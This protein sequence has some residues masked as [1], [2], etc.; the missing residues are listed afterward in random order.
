MRA[1]AAVVGAPTSSA[2]AEGTRKKSRRWGARRGH[3]SFRVGDALHCS[4]ERLGRPRVEVLV[5]SVLC[6]RRA[7]LGILLSSTATSLVGRVGTASAEDLA[8]EEP[9][10]VTSSQ[11]P[12]VVATSDERAYEI[13]SAPDEVVVEEIIDEPPPPPPGS[14]PQKSDDEDSTIL[15]STSDVDNLNEVDAKALKQN[16]QIQAQNRAPKGFPEFVR[17]GFDMFIF[18]DGYTQ[19]ENGLIYKELEAGE[20]GG[21][22]GQDGDEVT[23]HYTGYNEEGGFIDSSYK[24]KRPAQIRLG[25]G[26]MI[27]GFELAVKDMVPGSRR[28]VIIPPALGPPVGPA[29]FFSAKQY[30]VFDIQL[31]GIKSCVRQG[32]GIV[33]TV[34]CE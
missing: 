34:K 17:R 2:R 9:S 32:F 24:K 13:V 11:E 33:S 1:A 29:T 19:L 22:K 16:R 21:R 26:G 27:P 28:R 7:A 4:R 3:R 14:L 30:E 10:V 8:S 12:P 15:L 31:L 25:I 18:A 23:F 6:D 20:E 5:G